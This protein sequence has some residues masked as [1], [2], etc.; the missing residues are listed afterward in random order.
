MLS[1]SP[2]FTVGSATNV[3]SIIS[4]NQLYDKKKLFIEHVDGG[5][6]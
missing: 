6:Q 2:R 3:I 4:S 5:N 1:V